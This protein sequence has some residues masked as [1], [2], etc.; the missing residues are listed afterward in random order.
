MSEETQDKVGVTKLIIDCRLLDSLLWRGITDLIV[1]HKV[2]ERI[3]NTSNRKF[4]Y[5][6]LVTLSDAFPE[7]GEVTSVKDCTVTIEW[8]YLRVFNSV[9]NI[10]QFIDK[11]LYKLILQTEHGEKLTKGNYGDIKYE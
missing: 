6:I 7:H 2:N 11:D 1:K 4:Y 8:K 9:K 3:N 5:Q 10:L